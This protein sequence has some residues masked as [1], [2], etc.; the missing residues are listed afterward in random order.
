MRAN[1]CIY[2]AYSENGQLAIWLRT[3]NEEL[4]LHDQFQVEFYAAPRKRELNEL[5]AIISGH[6]LVESATTT[7]AYLKITDRTRSNVILVAAKPQYYRGL[8]WDLQSSDL[9]TLYNDE[10]RPVQRYF[11]SKRFRNFSDAHVEYDEQFRV[12]RLNE[13]DGSATP[14]LGV[15]HFQPGVGKDEIVT[16]LAGSEI[17]ILTVQKDQRPLIYELLRSEINSNGSYSRLVPGKLI[18]DRENFHCLGVAGLDEKSKFAH[19]PIG[20]VAAWGP[21]RTIDSLQCYEAVKRGILIPSTRAGTGGNVLTAKEISYTDRGALILSPQIGLHENVGELDFE[22]LFSNILVKFN[23]SYETATGSGVDQS[24]RG[25]LADLVEQFIQRRL[26]LKQAK[27]QFREGSRERDECGKRERLLKKLLVSFYGY[28]GSDLNRFGNVF[29][30]RE[31]NRI[32]RETIVGAMNVAMKEG[33]RVIYLDT[34]SIFVKRQDANRDDFRKLA[35]KIK[36]V[37]GFE[38][39]FASHYRYL[40]LLTQEADPEIEAARRFYGKLTDGNVYYRGIELI[41]HD[42]PVFMKRFQEKLLNIL[43]DADNASDVQKRQLPEAVEFTAKAVDELRLGN[44]PLDELV[45]SK[46]LRMP[47]ERYRSLFPHV[48]AAIQLHQKHRRVKAGDF[49]NYVYVDTNQV[50]P[51]NRVAP[52]EFAEFYDVE[53][54]VEILL[55]VAESI[56]GVFE[57]SR[58]QLGFQNRSR[59]FLD[60]VRSEMAKEVLTELKELQP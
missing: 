59:N 9:C 18:V 5:A 24:S 19:L 39:F 55:D 50:N 29:V 46:V 11:Y 35:E 32:A 47:V 13:S 48:T 6:P 16:Q 40:V 33:F 23:I 25:F 26:T 12:V 56:L 15:L 54:Y 30:Y 51:I 37:L 22:S 17:Q 31:I 57:F 4:K 58:K 38:I 21:S 14:N 45:I 10:L 42:Y 3:E 20:V 44:V 1:G 41:R 36:R 7:S 60:E 49:V 53:K 8:V 28:S 52:A 34:D 27:K 43:L 2:D